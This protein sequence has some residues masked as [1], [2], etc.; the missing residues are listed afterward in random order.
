MRGR[1][2]VHGLPDWCFVN[3]RKVEPT[4]HDFSIC[5]V[6]DRSMIPFVVAALMFDVLWASS[7]FI[8]WSRR[9]SFCHRLDTALNS[10]VD[11]SSELEITLMV[12]PTWR[13]HR[14]YVK[15]RR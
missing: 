1:P 15:T 9:A 12:Q 2:A 7:I 10:D 13:S 11:G 5:N 6:A 4:L 3:F 8:S 14:Q